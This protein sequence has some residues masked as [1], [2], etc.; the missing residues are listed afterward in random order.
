MDVEHTYLHSVA[1]KENNLF[2]WATKRLQEFKCCMQKFD[3]CPVRTVFD[4][5]IFPHS[6]RTKKK[7][8]R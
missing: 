5:S 3:I 6:D 4:A 1:E 7:P 8:E 2:K